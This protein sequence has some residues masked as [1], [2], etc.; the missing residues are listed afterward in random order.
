MRKTAV[1][2]GL[3]VASANAPGSRPAVSRLDKDDRAARHDQ[4]HR[5]PAPAVSAMAASVATT[6]VK[7]ARFA[8]TIST[9]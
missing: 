8:F 4:Y 5:I 2:G 9:P 1:T 7:R 3:G 6:Q